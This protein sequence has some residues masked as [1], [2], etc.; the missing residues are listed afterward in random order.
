M[1]FFNRIS[2]ARLLIFAS[3]IMTSNS[4]FSQA[5]KLGNIQKKWLEMEVYS[6]DSSASAV[7]ISD[8]GRNYYD[9]NSQDGSVFLK[10][11]R[12]VRIKIL[13]KEGLD[14]ANWEIMLYRNKNDKDEIESLKGYTYN[15]VNGKVE[16]TKF[17]EDVFKKDVSKYHY[18]ENFTFPNV[19]VGSVIDLEYVVNSPFMI[20]VDDWLF[21]YEIPVIKSEYTFDYPEIYE[22]VKRVNGYVPLTKATSNTYSKSI[23]R[24]VNYVK[25]GY[26]AEQEYSMEEF[27]LLFTKEYFLIENVPAFKKEAFLSSPNNY[28]SKAEFQFSRY[29][30]KYGRSQTFSSSWEDI[31]RNLLFDD[32]LGGEFKPIRKIYSSLEKIA[33]SIRE[34]F[35]DQNDQLV[36]AFDFIQNQMLWNKDYSIYPKTNLDNA[37]WEKTG[38]IGEINLSLLCLLRSLEINSFP[39]IGKT[40]Y[41]GFLFE[42]NPTLSDLNYLLV[43]AEVDGNGIILDA[44]EKDI[45]CGMLPE[46]ALNNK[47]W[48]LDKE[49][50]GF[51]DIPQTNKFKAIEMISGELNSDATI[52]GS[53]QASYAGYAG[54]EKRM[55]I[56]DAGSEVSFIQQVKD[57]WP[58]SEFSSFE[59]SNLEKP[60]EPLKETVE[61]E[62]K[63][64]CT[65]AGEFIYFNPILFDRLEENP[66]KLKERMYPV[67][68]MF[69]REKTYILNIKLPEGYTIDELPEN[70]KIVLPENSASFTYTINQA[71]ETIQV[72]SKIKINNTIFS[73]AEYDYLKQ[74]YNLIINKQAEQIVFKKI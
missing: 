10:L 64:A 2:I 31:N 46:R 11:R 66:F 29:I 12:T 19:K 48:M 35:P 50:F 15:L 33:Q 47:Y 62:L 17:K 6:K 60:S 39:L 18:S 28:V 54:L 67:D 7:I 41:S 49:N 8:F 9:F 14:W 72:I 13:T 56:M 34:E 68:F 70:A 55:E 52:H 37:F 73:S 20:N 24:R 25:D 43:Y 21:Q 57:N 69:G 5:V 36:A 32:D 3:I 74:F 30:P 1:P 45:Y 44:T 42:S 53:M 65:L 26:S 61:V 58:E 4:L 16:K 38:N 51:I 27:N 59:I 71:G 23:T 40:R 63:N 22:F